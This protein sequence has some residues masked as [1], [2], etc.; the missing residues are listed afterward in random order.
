[1]SSAPITSTPLSGGYLAFLRAMHQHARPRSYV[2][3]GVSKGASLALASRKT[4][5]VGI[6]PAP[7]IDRRLPRR[8]DVYAE[9]SD[10]FFVGHDLAAMIGTVDIAFIDGMHLFEQ[11]LRDFTNVERYMARDGVILIHD[12][13]PPYAEWASRSPRAGKWAGDVWKVLAILDEYR[14]DVNVDVVAVNP[15]GL[16]IV[17]VLDP[18]NTTFRDHHDEI[19]ARYLHRDE[20]PRRGALDG[21]WSA[22]EHLFPQYRPRGPL[23]RASLQARR[24]AR[25]LKRRMSLVTRQAT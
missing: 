25:G 16:G 19:V 1:V 9:T 5:V 13:Y 8:T 7:K 15:T 17:T 23:E 24:A 4:R 22:A 18:G 6:D 2:E 10:A 20:V 11:A 12:C 3:I 21:R 14:P